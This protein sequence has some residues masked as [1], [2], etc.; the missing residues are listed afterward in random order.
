M[1]SEMFYYVSEPKINV[2]TTV[3]VTDAAKGRVGV[4]RS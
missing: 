2:S 4:F 1:Y 3:F